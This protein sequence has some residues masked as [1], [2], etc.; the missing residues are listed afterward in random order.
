M[1]SER[2]RRTTKNVKNEKK[3]PFYSNHK[4][5]PILLTDILGKKNQAF[6][7]LRTS[8]QRTETLQLNNSYNRKG[9]QLRMKSNSI[10]LPRPFSFPNRSLSLKLRSRREIKAWSSRC[11]DLAFVQCSVQF[12]FMSW[13]FNKGCIVCSRLSP[14]DGSV[15]ENA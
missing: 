7:N 5:L 4:K 11:C 1:Q 2:N 15:Q 10:S 8:T 6:A 13:C 9:I 14:L 12:N 3:N